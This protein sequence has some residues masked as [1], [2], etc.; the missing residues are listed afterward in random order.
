MASELSCYE[1]CFECPKWVKKE[2]IVDGCSFSVGFHEFSW[3]VVFGAIF[4][5][6]KAGE[7]EK[8][9]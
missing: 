4:L 5:C 7:G 1:I 6:Q 3:F 9:C 2:M 8:S